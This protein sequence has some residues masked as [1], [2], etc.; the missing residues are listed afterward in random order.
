MQNNNQNKNE[1]NEQKKEEEQ[2]TLI[3]NYSQNSYIY[4]SNLTDLLEIHV[5]AVAKEIKVALSYIYILY[6][7]N[8]LSGLNFKKKIS[9]IIN[10]SDK[11]DKIMTLLVYI[12]TEIN[13]NGLDIIKIVLAIESVTTI[14]FKGERRD[15]IIDIISNSP[16]YNLNIKY[17]S[18]K[19]KN[20][21]IDIN[22]KFD[23][24]AD[25]KDK[26]DLKIEIIVYY[27]IPLIVD[28]VNE[29]NK[30]I[31]F[32]GS[33]HDRI[34]YYINAYCNNNNLDIDDF[35]LYYENKKFENYQYKIFYEIIFS[36]NKMLKFISDEKESN[37]IINFA[38]SD[39]LNKTNAP[40][41]NDKE[42]IIDTIIPV[43]PKNENK[44]QIEIKVVLKCCIVR[45]CR[46]IK[47]KI[48]KICKMCK[49][50][51]IK[52][53]LCCGKCKQGCSNCC[54][55][56]ERIIICI[57]SFICCLIVLFCIYGIPL[58]VDYNNKNNKNN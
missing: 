48:C 45:C 50:C 26:K 8:S 55:N 3:M 44:I 11:K 56:N 49:G 15:S 5:K 34:I 47:N 4:K 31:S 35:Y 32:K 9:E 57:C 58:L 38:S 30:K 37:H 6:S 33:L 43:L 16:K 39:N 23:D 29:K 51:K 40:I 12:D 21:E 17:C 7:G 27:T 1:K 53:S 10:E 42:K 54:N 13:K 28:F 20:I 19:Y 14:I 22:K 24:I 36:S 2:I 41:I 18:F 52:C 46:Y 25:D